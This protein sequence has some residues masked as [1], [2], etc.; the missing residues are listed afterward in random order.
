MN[1]AVG[2]AAETER[3]RQGTENAA[4]RGRAAAP[5]MKRG[6]LRHPFISSRCTPANHLRDHHGRNTLDTDTSP[7]LHPK[8]MFHG[9]SF[10]YG[11]EIVYQK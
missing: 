11:G 8:V 1:R 4:D 10:M 9:R 6:S 7:Q 5:S 2:K 3:L